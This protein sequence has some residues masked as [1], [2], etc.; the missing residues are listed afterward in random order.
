MRFFLLLCVAS[1]GACGSSGLCDQCSDAGSDFGGFDLAFD[2][3]AA[4]D[5]ACNPMC[6]PMKELASSCSNISPVACS[7][8]CV[9]GSLNAPAHCA[10]SP[11]NNVFCATYQPAVVF[12]GSPAGNPY[13][14]NVDA[15]PPLLKDQLGAT[16]GTGILMNGTVLF[17][18][19]SVSMSDPSLH[20][21]ITVI[22]SHPVA[23]VTES[24]FE[25]SGRIDVSGSPGMDA[26]LGV[27][28][29]A[30]FSAGYVSGG[31]AGGHPGGIQGATSIGEDGAG[32]SGGG[33]GGALPGQVPHDGLPGSYP[34]ICSMY[35]PGA[36]GSST[37]QSATME[38]GSA[39]ASSPTIKVSGGGG[40]GVVQITAG[41]SLVLA[42]SIDATGGGGGRGPYVSA[43]SVSGP[44]GFGGGGG[45]GGGLIWLEAPSISLTGWGIANACL[46]VLGGGGGGG[47][48]LTG[49]GNNAVKR[50]APSTTTDGCPFG[51]PPGLGGDGTGGG[52]VPASGSADV[53]PSVVVPNTGT[54]GGGGGGG[55]GRVVIRTVAQPVN[56]A[57]SIYPSSIADVYIPRSL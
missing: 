1:A 15:T 24:N 53:P 34:P 18:F 5:M 22:G 14:V 28:G 16:V 33:G 12:A 46:S 3:A 38:G 20:A 36:G 25:F 41:Y 6:L 44:A 35:C 42:G 30:G 17:C 21:V 10:P 32:G 8:G 39:G 26:T 54:G 9:D 27:G 47:A 55:P 23:F 57:A 4:A 13:T 31:P 11:S 43:T 50:P 56:A 37:T 40:G 49:P 51:A 19:K 52:G 29:P 7:F 48:S 2:V 45:G